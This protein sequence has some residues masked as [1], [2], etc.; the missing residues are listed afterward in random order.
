MPRLKPRIGATT[1]SATGTA[2]FVKLP[3]EFEAAFVQAALMLG[4]KP[5]KFRDTQHRRSHRK[6]YAKYFESVSDSLPRYEG[7]P[8]RLHGRM[9][10]NDGSPMDPFEKLAVA[11]MWWIDEHFRNK[12]ADG[13]GD[14]GVLRRG[15]P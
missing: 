5:M 10:D 9:S 11:Y 1:S 4:T 2:H 13:P 14:G 6:R 3:P 15:S 7:W 8:M 12:A